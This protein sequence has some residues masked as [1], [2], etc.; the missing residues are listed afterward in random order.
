MH[1]LSLAF[2]RLVQRV[3]IFNLDSW[4]YCKIA[5]LYEKALAK[6]YADIARKVDEQMKTVKNVETAIGMLEKILDKLLAMPIPEIFYSNPLL[7]EKA[8][9]KWLTVPFYELDQQAAGLLRVYGYDMHLPLLKQ[10]ER[11]R[12]IGSIECYLERDNNDSE[13]QSNTRPPKPQTFTCVP[14]RDITLY[15]VTSMM[16]RNSEAITIQPAH[17]IG[18]VE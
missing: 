5:A 12:R 2:Y 13:S 15:A 6:K 4:A 17:P 10:C 11:I 7:A 1:P 8:E 9:G 16:S 14:L 3:A 18:E